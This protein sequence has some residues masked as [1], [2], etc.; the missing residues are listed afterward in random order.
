MKETI[1]PTRQH[2]NISSGEI[3]IQLIMF[4]LQVAYLPQAG[5]AALQDWFIHPV[6]YCNQISVEILMMLIQ[7]LCSLGE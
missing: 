6:G 3:E 7:Y 4:T 2:L 1:C 5:D